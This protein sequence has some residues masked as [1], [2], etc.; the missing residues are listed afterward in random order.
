MINY[1]PD[2][3]ELV[4]CIKW[5]PCTDGFVWSINPATCKIRRFYL[6]MIF[7]KPSIYSVKFCTMNSL[8]EKIVI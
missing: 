3:C 7:K 5:E 4:T 8:K 2:L 6:M 1:N